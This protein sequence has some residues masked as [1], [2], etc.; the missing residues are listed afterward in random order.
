M[1]EVTDSIRNKLIMKVFYNTGMTTNELSN[2]FI[3]DINFN[4]GIG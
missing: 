1:L 3:K 2:L 4:T